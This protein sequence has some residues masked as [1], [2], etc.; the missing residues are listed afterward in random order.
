MQREAEGDA[1][2]QSRG[3]RAQEYLTT[4]SM[5]ATTSRVAG[6]KMKPDSL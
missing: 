6:E 1:F 2:A 5:S 4:T 3:E